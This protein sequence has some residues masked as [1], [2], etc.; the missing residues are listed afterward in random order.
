MKVLLSWLNELAPVGDDV[1]ALADTMNELGLAVD[2]I[3]TVGAPIDGVVV[4]KVL[5]L[6]RHPDADRMQ[7]VDVDTGDGEPLQICCGAFNMAAGDL[8]P[9]ATVGTV[10]PDGRAISRAKKRGNGRTACCAHLLS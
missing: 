4:A 6:R 5:A 9:L 3:E 7:L 2:G 10:M 8:V 1:A